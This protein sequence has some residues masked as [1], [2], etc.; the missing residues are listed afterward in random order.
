MR[1]VMN[2]AKIQEEF[3]K[4]VVKEVVDQ[5]RK[6]LLDYVINFQI[7]KMMMVLMELNAK[8]KLL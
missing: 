1:R 4:V 8:K 2:L 7:Q 3:L 6:N 5:G